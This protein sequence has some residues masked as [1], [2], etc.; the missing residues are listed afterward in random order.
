MMTR[1]SEKKYALGTVWG[2]SV[3]IRP[4]EDAAVIL[5]V[6]ICVVILRVMMQLM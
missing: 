6:S 4:A 1:F 2:S 3:R 5:V